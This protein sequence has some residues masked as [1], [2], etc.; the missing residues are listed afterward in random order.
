V[1]KSFLVHVVLVAAV[2]CLQASPASAF[3]VDVCYNAPDSGLAPIRNCIGV[4]EV[5]RTSNLSPPLELGCRV[6]ATADSLSGLSGGNSIIGGRSLLHSDST[7]LMAQLIGFTPWQ[8]YQVMIYNEATDQSDYFPF[9]QDGRQML[10]DEEIAGCRSNWGY[11][12][13][14]YCWVITPE[15]NGLY[16]FNDEDGGMLLHLHARLSPDG[17]QPPAIGFPADYF[18][19]AN[20]PYEPL[21]N[22]L[23]DWAFDRRPDA[24]VA[25]IVARTSKSDRATPRCEVRDRVIKS[26]Q[27]FFAAGVSQLQIPFSSQLGRLVVNRDERGTV[28]AS[29][30][31]FQDYI[32]PHQLG[33][34]KLGVFLHALGDRISHHMCTD[35]SWF[36][37]EAS[38]DYNSRYDQVACAQGSHFLWH[39][40]E[41]GTEQER[42]NL[43]VRY[44][45][46]RPALESVYDQLL[47][48]ARLRGLPVN[49]GIDKQVIIDRLVAVLGIFDPQQRLDAMVMLMEEYKVLPLPGH[50]SA[51][52]LSLEQWLRAAGAQQR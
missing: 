15:V 41:Q 7:Y 4:E 21:I 42:G 50:G 28:H 49:G 30:R 5:C 3:G 18:S 51:A 34:A 47:A 27:S 37:R 31:S 1:H 52:K 6:A 43:E 19:S 23:R 13:P 35:R 22:N 11:A 39:A 45:T 40:W 17:S 16:K 46:L 24:C 2:L 26:P 25:G 20:A 44:Q 36:Q 10:S 9:G 33:F 8:A 32:A 48:S 12:M 38:G 14:R 29:D